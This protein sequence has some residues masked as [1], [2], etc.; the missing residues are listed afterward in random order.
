M[1]LKSVR[2]LLWA[3]VVLVGAGALGAYF[4]ARPAEGGIGGPFAL[5]DNKGNP[6]TETLL[7]GQPSV[8]F[9]G[10]T[11]CPEV[12][13]TTLS[14]MVGWFDALGEEGKA[15][16]A[17]FVTVDPERD[18]PEVMDGYVTSMSDRITGLTGTRA[19]IDRMIANWRIYAKKVPIEG[20]DYTM[21]H[22]ASVFL[23]DSKGRFQ[24]TIAYR[25]D[26]KT[27]VE[28]LKLLISKG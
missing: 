5:I 14:E 1:T 3:L 26:T 23:I 28:K 2:T 17:F 22:T 9:F 7:E 4:L 21:D 11:H 19:E 27:A 20:G 10:F 13:P 25:E 6:V 18:T 16:K 12:C 24:G 8:L 15:L